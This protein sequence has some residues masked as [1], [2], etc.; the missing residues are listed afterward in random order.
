MEKNN[1]ETEKIKNELKNTL[2]Y[3]YDIPFWMEVISSENMKAFM[4][5]VV[6]GEGDLSISNEKAE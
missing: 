3:K 4:R 6:E 2:L 1:K 5:G